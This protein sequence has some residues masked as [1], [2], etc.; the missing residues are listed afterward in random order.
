MIRTK[1][2]E[3]VLSQLQICNQLMSSPISSF[4]LI[5]LRKLYIAIIKK[6]TFV[7]P[8]KVTAVT[9]VIL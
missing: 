8:S 5:I 7:N 4:M 2:S 9:F 3:I 1:K 6:F